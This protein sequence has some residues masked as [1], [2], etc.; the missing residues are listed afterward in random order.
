MDKIKFNS[1]ILTS[2]FFKM[3][4]YV[5]MLYRKFF[6]GKEFET[7]NTSTVQELC[8]MAKHIPLFAVSEI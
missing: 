2:I 7:A 3:L 5:K 6:K 8:F 4:I 1:I